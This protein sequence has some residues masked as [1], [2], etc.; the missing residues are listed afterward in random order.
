MRNTYTEL[1]LADVKYDVDLTDNDF[2]ELVEQY[3]LRV[4]KDLYLS[5]SD[6]QLMP[7]VDKIKPDSCFVRKLLSFCSRH[8]DACS[9]DE[10]EVRIFALPVLAHEARTLTR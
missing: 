2:K 6:K 10:R 4:R 5:R 1:K 8:K 9:S 3:S 7:E